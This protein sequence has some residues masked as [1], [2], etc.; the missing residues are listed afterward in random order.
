MQMRRLL[1]LCALG[2][3][4]CDPGYKAHVTTTDQGKPVAD[5]G[6]STICPGKTDAVLLEGQTGASGEWRMHGLGGIGFECE[7]A[8]AWPSGEKSRYPVKDACKRRG[9]LIYRAY[10][11]EMDVEATR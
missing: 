3:V 4:A 1:M 8:I 2:L 10:C 7:V 11:F 6:I 9:E 5:A